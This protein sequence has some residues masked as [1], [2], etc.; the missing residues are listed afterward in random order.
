MVLFCVFFFNLPIL[1]SSL[2]TLETD[3]LFQA[4]QVALVVKNMPAKA[5]DIRDV[6]SIPRWGRFPGG[7]NGNPLQ[8]SCLGNP[9]DRETRQAT[10]Q[11]YF[12]Y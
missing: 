10:V 2:Q 6:S 1:F 8:S 9:M 7:G 5:G 3:I 4:S 12:D 11:F